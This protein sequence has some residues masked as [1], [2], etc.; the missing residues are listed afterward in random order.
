M[1]WIIKGILRGVDK[2]IVNLLGVQ[3]GS[4]PIGQPPHY[5]NPSFGKSPGHWSSNN[6]DGHDLVKKIYDQIAL[7]WG[8]ASR[9]P[10]VQNWRWEKQPKIEAR[11]RSPEVRLEKAIVKISSDTWPEVTRWVNQVPTSSGLLNSTSDRKRAID[12][13]YK[14]EGA[15][16]NSYHFIELK[17]RSNN[18]V[19]AAME[20]LVYG[21]LYLVARD[22]RDMKPYTQAS[23]PL[24][25]AE[26]IRLIVLAPKP[27]YDGYFGLARL[28]ETV[29]EGL[30]RFLA[31]RGFPMGFEFQMFPSDFDPRKVLADK[32]SRDHEIANALSYRRRL[33]GTN[34]PEAMARS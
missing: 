3:L 9:T 26:G 1:G 18:P 5:D 12:L 22:R 31:G 21:I 14:D 28:E 10:S 7:N 16:P 30:V 34:G 27:Y 6:L 4:N 25:W 23:N 11:N 24:L 2:I 29:D 33:F 17:V 8:Q 15:D 20:S 19:F 13:V 32:K